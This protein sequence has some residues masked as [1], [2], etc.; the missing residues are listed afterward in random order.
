MYRQENLHNIRC[1]NKHFLHPNKII[2]VRE[3][4]EAK[5]VAVYLE[6][7]EEE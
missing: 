3:V 2:K 6:E 1:H 5:T 7:A 4:S